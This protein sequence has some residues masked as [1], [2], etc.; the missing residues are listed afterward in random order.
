MP[1]GSLPNSS[2]SLASKKYVNMTSPT[3]VDERVFFGHE[4]EGIAIP[5]SYFW[6]LE[7]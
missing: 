6:W 4:N 5:C 1:V 7:E 3:V 2:G